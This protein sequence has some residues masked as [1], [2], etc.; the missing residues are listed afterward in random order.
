MWHK[1]GTFPKPEI[2]DAEATCPRHTR[3][4]SRT[5]ADDG[6]AA[7]LADLRLQQGGR[8]RAAARRRDL[9]RV[10]RTPQAVGPARVSPERRR[11]RG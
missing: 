1:S 11:Q 8:I 9:R 7:C 5:P 2:P 4:Q 3:H 10:A 6:A